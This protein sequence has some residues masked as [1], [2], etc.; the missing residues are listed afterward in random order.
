MQ[1]T[2]HVVTIYVFAVLCGCQDIHET[3]RGGSE[4]FDGGGSPKGSRAVGVT[5]D[6]V[7]RIQPST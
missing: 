1:K 4:D 6:M 3:E 5:Y 2:R 7:M